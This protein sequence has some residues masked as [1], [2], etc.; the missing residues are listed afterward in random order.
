MGKGEGERGVRWE[1]LGSLRLVACSDGPNVA[2]DSVP[3]W[4]PKRCMHWKA[5]RTT[6]F[7]SE[8]NAPD[9]RHRLQGLYNKG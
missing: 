5:A 2:P 4:I 1:T 9:R 7:L 8:Q 6:Q 3:P